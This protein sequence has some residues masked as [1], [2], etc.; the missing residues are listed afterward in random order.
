M[1]LHMRMPKR[2][3]NNP[4]APGAGRSEPVALAAGR[5]PPASSTPRRAERR[6]PLVAAGVIRRAKDG[7]RLLGE[8]RDLKPP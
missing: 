4:F 1:P 6:Q 7:V 2:G 5:S 8:G 3:F